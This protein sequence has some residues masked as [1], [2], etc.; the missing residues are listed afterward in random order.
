MKDDKLKDFIK[1]EDKA[2][3]KTFNEDAVW[4][5]I[6]NRIAKKP[7]ERTFNW[8]AAASIVLLLTVGWLT[9]ER[10]T[11]SNKVLALE[12]IMVEGKNYQQIESYYTQTISQKN[13]LVIQQAK[14]IDFPL[15][16]DITDLQKKYKQLKIQ[17]KKNGVNERVINAMIQNLRTQVDLLNEQLSIIESI[18]QYVKTDKSKKN[19]TQI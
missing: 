2:F 16:E 5:Q 19:D 11:L 8:L 7:K 4:E 3:H 6:E 15:S 14:E 12:Q 13:Q 17:L 1:V 9:L 18:N 10:L